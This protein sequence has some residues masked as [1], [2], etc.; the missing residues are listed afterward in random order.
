MPPAD[1][2]IR[3]ATADD[4][5]PLLEIYAPF[6][7]DTAISFEIEVPT[8]EDFRGRMES[9]Q[10]RWAWL[11]AEHDGAVIGYAYATAFRSRAAYRWSAETSAYVRD[12]HRGRGV[13]KRLYEEL[14]GRLK[15][16]GYCNAYA[17]IAMPNDA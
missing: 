10:S 15:M 9:A 4:A 1:F 5:G 6:V 16:K 13:A 11:V 12:G 3:D 8:V 7:T 17:G 2:L 14:L